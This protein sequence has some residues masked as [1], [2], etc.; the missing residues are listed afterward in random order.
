VPADPAAAP[1]GD[2]GPGGVAP[3]PGAPAAGEVVVHVAGAV[4]APGVQRLPG[5]ARVD[6]AVDAAGGATPDADLG[7]I[8]LA[9][10]LIDG[11][12]V[13]VLRVGEAPP[14]APT[15]S[16]GSATANTAGTEGQG[17]LVDIN[18]AS[19]TQLEE[20]PGVGPITAQ[21]IISHREQSGPFASVDDLLDVRGI[22]EAKLEAL[23]DL[24]TV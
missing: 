18:T 10:V 21:A 8:N 9:A 3:G 13:Y 14:S 20:L 22:G 24:A 15:A 11:Q 6:D 23:R 17:A 4:V 12:Q 7:R 16:A 2:A 5:G 1:P 19:A